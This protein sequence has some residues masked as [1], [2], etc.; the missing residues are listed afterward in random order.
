[1]SQ[2][3]IVLE[4]LDRTGKTSIAQRISKIENVPN[5]GNLSG[6][7]CTVP[8]YRKDVYYQGVTDAYISVTNNLDCFVKDR[9]FLST[10]VYDHCLRNL[11]KA[12]FIKNIKDYASKVDPNIYFFIIVTDYITYCSRCLFTNEVPLPEEMFMKMRSTF[13]QCKSLLESSLLKC[14]LIENPASKSIEEITRSVLA[15]I[16]KDKINTLI[17]DF[18]YKMDS[19]TAR[20]ETIELIDKFVKDNPERIIDELFPK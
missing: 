1:M 11:D 6:E 5:L 18:D 4:G 3:K 13:I 14:F 2:L 17:Y 19:P 15:E 9:F 20:E 12:N 8:N 7:V 10:V 16:Y